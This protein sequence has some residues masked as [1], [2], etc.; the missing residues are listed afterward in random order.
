M[1]ARVCSNESDVIDLNLGCP[2][3]IAAKGQYGAFLLEDDPELALRCVRALV[4]ATPRPVSAKIRLQSTNEATLDVAL[5]LQ[6]AGVR[7]ARARL[8]ALPVR[9][10]RA[11]HARMLGSEPHANM[12]TPHIHAHVHVQVHFHVHAHMWTCA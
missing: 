4:A 5:Q 11:A 12:P 1:A 10:L 2:Q 6:E 3:A 7:Y 8:R 9:V